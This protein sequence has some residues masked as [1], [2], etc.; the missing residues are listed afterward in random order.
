[1]GSVETLRP[2]RMFLWVLP[3]LPEE[4]AGPAC[5]GTSALH[6]GEASAMASSAHRL[7]GASL[8]PGCEPAHGWTGGGSIA[9]ESGRGKLYLRGGSASDNSCPSV[10]TASAPHSWVTSPRLVEASP[11]QASSLSTSVSP[12][13][14]EKYIC[15]TCKDSSVPGKGASFSPLFSCR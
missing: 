9:Q 8:G 13:G 12:H 2:G 7:A 10:C 14:N 3:G 5:A 1:M 15:L 11:W 6:R 4:W